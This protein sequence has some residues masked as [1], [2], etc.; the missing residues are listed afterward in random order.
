MMKQIVIVFALTLIILAALSNN[1]YIYGESPIPMK[2][3]I[4]ESTSIPTDNML[5]MVQLK[6][7]WPIQ[8]RYDGCVMLHNDSWICP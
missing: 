7:Y 2:S 8:K 1:Q 6:R 3:H 4:F 5:E